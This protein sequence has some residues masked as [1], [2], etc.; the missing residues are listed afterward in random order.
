MVY[1]SN[2]NENWAIFTKGTNVE[3]VFGA[4]Q[5]DDAPLI[6]GLAKGLESLGQKSFQQESIASIILQDPNQKPRKETE[7]FIVSLEGNYFFIVS[8]PIITSKLLKIQSDIIPEE[9]SLL[10]RGVLVGQAVITY[11]DLWWSSNTKYQRI[12]D[13]IFQSGLL[14]IGIDGTNTHIR[15]SGGECNLSGLEVADLL[16]LN[17]Y[18]RTRLQNEIVP[19]ITRPWAYI[20][21]KTL[22]PVHLMYNFRK[23][24]HDEILAF[25][26]SNVITFIRAIFN[27]EPSALI[28]RAGPSALSVKIVSGNSNVFV[29][30]NP[31]LLFQKTDFVTELL[32]LPPGVHNDLYPSLQRFLADEIIGLDHK[33]LLSKPV[34]DLI[35]LM[36]NKA[37]NFN[38]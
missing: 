21:D 35:T 6:A 3:W 14:Q 7:L 4:I 24:E 11:A 8:D 19:I 18:L 17:S 20:M 9:I 37:K 5:D 1:K 15:A 33:H 12:I 27:L 10:L 23:E 22:T 34:I 30:C 28:F 29:I 16:F 25:F 36:G 38:K 31:L 26:F 13:E 32:K 2:W